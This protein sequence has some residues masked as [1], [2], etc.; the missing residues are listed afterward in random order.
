MGQTHLPPC[1]DPASCMI[2]EPWPLFPGHCH[3]WKTRQRK[4][5]KQGNQVSFQGGGAG[6]TAEE[7]SKEREEELESKY[8]EPACQGCNQMAA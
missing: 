3:C 6:P 1:G 7:R 8:G 5:W 4:R 2:L